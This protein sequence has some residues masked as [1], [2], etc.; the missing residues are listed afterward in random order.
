MS[1]S[2]KTVEEEAQEYAIRYTPRGISVFDGVEYDST[3]R[4]I[5]NAYI[6][7]A[8]S[9][10]ERVAELE[11]ERDA[12]SEQL[13]AEYEKLKADWNQQARFC[14]ADTLKDATRIRELEAELRSARAKAFEDA[15]AI[16]RKD[17]SIYLEC[18]QKIQNHNHENFDCDCVMELDAYDNKAV[19]ARRIA[20][21]LE[22]LAKHEQGER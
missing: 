3:A 12:V 2:K 19:A 14:T 5:R 4:T 22:D 7:G 1:E 20:E 10:E 9:R 11:Q 17:Y 15:A 21:Q 16:A 13:E 6:A 8:R 18:C